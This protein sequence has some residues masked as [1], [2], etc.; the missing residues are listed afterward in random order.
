MPYRFCRTVW[1]QRIKLLST[2]LVI[3]LY[4]YLMNVIS[5]LKWYSYVNCYLNERFCS[6]SL[7]SRFVLCLL[8]CFTVL[9][10]NSALQVSG[11]HCVLMKSVVNCQ[12][13]HALDSASPAS[14]RT[15][16]RARA[17]IWWRHNGNLL[18][19][20]SVNYSQAV[21]VDAC[22]AHTFF[23]DLWLGPMTRRD[24]V[25]VHKHSTMRVKGQLVQKTEWKKIGRTDGR[26]D[27]HDFP[28]IA[29]GKILRN[30]VF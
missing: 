25:M 12:L 9:F 29:V 3:T 10:S 7:F 28:A 23:I 11:C 5:V 19:R 18:L 30:D 22:V 27:R 21:A 17:C 14:H 6:F 15:R 24:M 4:L 26:H 13:S 1:N 16:H 8:F 2:E 20:P